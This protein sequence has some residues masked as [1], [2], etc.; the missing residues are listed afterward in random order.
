MKKIEEMITTTAN[1]QKV[2]R[3]WSDNYLPKGF[4]VG[5]KGHVVT[6]KGKGVKYKIIDI[7]ENE[8]LSIMW[9]SV[10]VKMVFHYKVKPVANGSQISCVVELKGF[11]AS[12][13]KRLIGRKIKAQITSALKHFRNQ[14]EV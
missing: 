14:L 7:I 12:F 1:Y 11:F 8:S 5:R 9:Y 10:I 4:E 3:A 13:L 6:Q 2:W